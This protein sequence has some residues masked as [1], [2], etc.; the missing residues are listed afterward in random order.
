MDWLELTIHYLGIGTLTVIILGALGLLLLTVVMIAIKFTP[1]L[2]IG[3][4]ANEGEL[5]FYDP[6]SIIS[7]KNGQQIGPSRRMINAPLGIKWW[8]GLSYRP[9]PKW[10]VGVIRW[11][12]KQDA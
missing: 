6:R 2:H 8:C 9:A 10:F 12:P 11:E 4:P 7:G 3:I 1:R 5:C